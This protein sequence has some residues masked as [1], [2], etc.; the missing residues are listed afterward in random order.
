MENKKKLLLSWSNM[1]I[2]NERI[3]PLIPILSKNFDVY[4]VLTPTHK[5]IV[6]LILHTLQEWEKAHVLKKVYIGAE[7]SKTLSIYSFINSL[8]NKLKDVD[9]D[10]WVTN[11][12]NFPEIA[13]YNK[14]ICKKTFKIALSTNTT[15]LNYYLSILGI[16]VDEYDSKININTITGLLETNKSKT[17]KH[18]NKTFNIR[19]KLKTLFALIY[20]Q[21]SNI[22]LHY[23]NDGKFIFNELRHPLNQLT[24][25]GHKVF[26][27]IL[28]QTKLE[29]QAHKTLFKT[30]NIKTKCSVIDFDTNTCR[31]NSDTIKKNILFAT[32]AFVGEY[33]APEPYK[34]SI[35]KSLQTI[36]S[37][38]GK[39]TIYFKQ[40]PAE[41]GTWVEKL[42]EYLN[43]NDIDSYVLDEEYKP[44]RDIACD[45]EIVV[46]DGSASSRDVI[47][48]CK[49]ITSILLEE[50]SNYNINNPKIFFAN[51][52]RLAWVN[53]EY[54]YES[55]KTFSKSKIAISDF[56]INI[57][58]SKYE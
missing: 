53:R 12:A 58:K 24:M 30:E 23:T 44:L 14:L 32:T 25:F 51:T 57:S 50:A 45:Y 54:V 36:Q 17:F 47:I 43:K 7:F 55:S 33:D 40:H 5:Y 31:C 49:Y 38:F 42:V 19:R 27:E 56:F 16:E 4:L 15:N 2:F 20:R 21:I 26:D 6:K 48:D 3:I 39:K 52:D 46:S 29:A 34:V 28:F 11:F 41:T 13:I 1:Y 18:Q 8:S 9:F 22:L 37:E 10:V 35:L